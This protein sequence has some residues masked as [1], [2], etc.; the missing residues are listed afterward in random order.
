VKQQDTTKQ[1]TGLALYQRAAEQSSAEVIA[2]YSTS[3]GF[4]TKLLPEPQRTHVTNIYALVRVADEIV[5]GSAEDARLAGGLA[6]PHRIL[7]DLEREIYKSIDNRFSAN[8]VVHAFANTAFVTGFGR[9]LIRPFFESM[10]MDLW[11][12]GHDQKSFE[13]YVYGSAEVVGLMC[14]QAFLLGTKVSASEMEKLVVGAQALGAA[15]QKVNFLRD[16][17]ADSSGLGRSYLPGIS[18]TGF[19]E[20]D[21]EFW[22]AD[23]QADLRKSAE[24]IPLIPKGSRRA[25]V[26]AYLLFEA[27][28]KKIAAT[29]ASEI[30]RRRIRVSNFSKLLIV[31]KAWMGATPK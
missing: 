11:K 20:K 8:L 6:D 24:S 15:F 25:V 19:S 21:K 27:L 13:K 2:S 18:P 1:P 9:T 10:R 5:D 17:A 4:A 3:F 30:I 22:V 14:L 16:L 29:P 28:N 26:A 12:K 7:D 31:G 23:I